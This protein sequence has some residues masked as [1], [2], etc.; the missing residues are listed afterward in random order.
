MDMCYINANDAGRTASPL[1]PHRGMEKQDKL[2][3]HLCRPI[4]SSSTNFCVYDLCMYTVWYIQTGREGGKADTFT[5]HYSSRALTYDTL[6]F[7]KGHSK[8]E[9]RL[10]N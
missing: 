5:G 10:E 9:L 6:S 1:D 7:L 8:M 4:S 3:S 2:R